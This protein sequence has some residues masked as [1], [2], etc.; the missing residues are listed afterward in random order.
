[1]FS[2]FEFETLT[3]PVA[4]FYVAL[5]LGVLFGLLAEQT[6]F[7]FRR[8]A[9]GPDRRQAGGV[10]AMAL[11]IAILGTQAAV[12]SGIIDFSQH[13]FL[14]SG[15]PVVAIL[16]G[17]LLFGAG[18][19]LTRG[20]ASR[21]TVL[22]GTGNIRALA[23]L[24][25]FAIAANAT[26]K[27]PLAQTRLDLGALKINIASIQEV[28]VSYGAWIGVAL[29]LALVIS[30]L[31]SGNSGSLLIRAAGIGAVVAASWS[32]TGYVL[33][34]DFDVISLESVAFTLTA[35]DTLFW[36]TAS[37]VVET[38]FTLGL[39]AGVIAGAGIAAA[40]GRRFAWVGF[41]GPR[42]MGRYGLGAIMM[43]F[44]GV[45]AGGCTVG[46][47]L[48]GIPTLSIATTL[49]VISMIAGAKAMD[50]ALSAIPSFR[51]YA[52]LNTTL[53]QQPAE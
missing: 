4:S 35:A 16:L 31:R 32:V 9:V 7:C 18:M 43:G 41:D 3:A 6:K 50:Y 52:E 49:A 40:I 24:I 2:E 38:K 13:R 28:V 17:G 23:T 33:Y 45:T 8:A 14:N 12:W 30:A 36:I 53:P 19:I 42:Q 20:C 15:M 48:A 46:A 11:A 22:S 27:G 51:G 34:D 26:L 25:V 37:S 5:V 1:M 47:G 44:G 29:A 21:L 10:W 39:I